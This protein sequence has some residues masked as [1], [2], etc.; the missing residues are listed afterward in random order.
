MEE[1]VEVTDMKVIKVEEVEAVVRKL[2]NSNGPVFGS[3][4]E[5]PANSLSDEGVDHISKVDHSREM[6]DQL[7]FFSMQFIL[8]ELSGGR[9]T[10]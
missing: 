5:G 2:S 10:V 8:S 6:P 4:R 3:H 7:G 1:R 9:Q